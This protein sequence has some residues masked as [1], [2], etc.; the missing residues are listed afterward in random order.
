MD[1]LSTQITSRTFDTVR[2]GYDPGAVDA[3]LK[4]LA[5]QV[6]RLEDEIRVGRSRIDAL[7]RQTRDVKD[8]DTVVRTAFLAAAEA[9][10]N[11]MAEAEEKASEILAG[12]ELKAREMAHSAAAATAGEQATALIVEAERKLADS[13]RVAAATREEAE[14]AAFAIIDSA[15]ERASEPPGAEPS[16][17]AA[18]A[19][20]LQDLLDTLGSLKEAAR[21]GVQRA[22]SLDA[23]IGTA[24]SD[25]RSAPDRKE[26]A[27]PVI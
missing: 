21:E 15:R 5:D 22:A 9:K 17:A 13:E 12:A 1:A 6:A 25:A 7:E 23:E 24:V 20:E 18:A 3:Y 2:R 14:R 19:A 8:A 10:A 4:R 11:L 16:G 27:E 26:P